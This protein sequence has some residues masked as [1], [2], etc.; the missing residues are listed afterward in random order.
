M[1]YFD[2]FTIGQE[3]TA[4]YHSYGDV[5]DIKHLTVTRVLKNG[6]VLSD[7]SRWTKSGRWWGADQWSRCRLVTRAQGIEREQGQAEVVAERK[8]RLAM[9]AKVEAL[10][11]ARLDRAA[12]LEAARDL[13]TFLEKHQ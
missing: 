7:G 2:S 5:D 12:L 6:A 8:F 9:T 4:I 13:V 3:V 10:R 1:S 11:Q